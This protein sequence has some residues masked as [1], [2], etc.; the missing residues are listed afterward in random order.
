MFGNM[1]LSVEELVLNFL[2]ENPGS[3]PRE[4][5]E[6]LGISY[7]RV[8]IAL[9]KLREKGL[10]MRTEK[11]YTATYRA[12]F[13]PFREE[14]KHIVLRQV[15]EDA[16]QTLSEKLSILEK[17]VSTMERRIEEVENVLEKLKTEIRDLEVISKKLSRNLDTLKSKLNEFL[18]YSKKYMVRKQV[19]DEFLSLLSAEKIL[20][21]NKARSLANRPIEDYVREN[22]VVVVSSYVVDKEFY[23]EFRKLFP[24]SKDEVKLLDEKFKLLLRVMID[25]GLAYLHRG[26]EYRI[27]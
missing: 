9:Y 17:K 15:R 16:V 7:N 5:A 13:R 18:K 25:E 26:I 24:I 27:A 20:S 21:I 8:R 3:K 4:I 10:V 23:D 22:K 19:E 12:E 11:G 2:K 1:V 14:G 6:A